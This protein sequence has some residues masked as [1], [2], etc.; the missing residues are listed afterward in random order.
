MLPDFRLLPDPGLLP[1]L[2]ARE[3]GE[4]EEDYNAFLAFLALH[5]GRRSISEAASVLNLPVQEIVRKS[6]A[7]NWV[8]RA[9]R[10][11]RAVLDAA[12]AASAMEIASAVAT[13]AKAVS[14]LARRVLENA[15]HIEVDGHVAARL[16][17]SV[18]AFFKAT[19]SLTGEQSSHGAPL[20]QILQVISTVPSQPPA[21]V[22]I[23]NAGQ[24]ALIPGDA[25][26]DEAEG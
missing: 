3:P 12:R 2:P 1:D 10:Y 14:A 7:Y 19:A 16:L 4:T 20:A 9:R 6:V 24:P 25:T 23:R 26:S 15:D 17:E 13:A 8:E 21:I 18:S 5:P 22:S 11:D